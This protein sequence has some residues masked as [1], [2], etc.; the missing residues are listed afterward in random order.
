MAEPVKPRRRYNNS[1]RQAQAS[2]TRA[3][4]VTAARRLFLA[5]GYQATTIEAIG[6]AADVPLA[7]LYRLFGSK[8]GILAAVLD[9]SFVG[10][11]EPLAL[12]D[13]PDARAAAAE[14]DPQRLLAGYAR[15]ARGVLERSGPLQQMLRTAAVVDPECADLLETTRQQRLDGQSRITAALA[16]QHR[17]PVGLTEAD[18][19]DIIYTLMSPEVHH[20]LTV[21]RH[22]HADKFEQW[23]GRILTAAL[24]RPQPRRSKQT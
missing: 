3:D 20:I 23:L 11:D 19:L 21:E 10:D 8:R 7:T 16:R 4:V 18:A 9:A 6:E 1:R 5:R 24:L 22:W 14:T 13:R 17:L 12:H 15:V 2:A